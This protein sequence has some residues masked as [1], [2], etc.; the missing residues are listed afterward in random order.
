MTYNLL[1]FND[2]SSRVP[3]FMAILDYAQPD[4]LVVQE[5][6]SQAA[7]DYFRDSILNVVNPGEWSSAAFTDGSEDDNALFYRTAKVEE[8]SHFDIETTSHQIDEWGLRPVGYD[9]PNAELRLYAAHLSP[10]QGGS[11]QQQRLSEVTAMR[12][13]METFP[14]GQN[15]VVCGDLNLYKSDEPAFQYMLSSDNGAAGLVADPMNAPGDW[16]DGEEFV[17]LHTQATRTSSGGGGMDDRFDFILRAPALEDDEGLDLLEPTYAA[18]GQDGL[19]FNA[20]IIDPPANA[21]VPQDIAQALYTASDH[22]PVLVDFQLPPIIVASDALDFGVA[23][24]GGIVPRDVSISNGAAAPADELDYTLSAPGPF[25][26]P[27]GSFQVE[28]GAPANVHTIIMSSDIAGTFA[29]N[30]TIASDDLDSPE[31]FI[32]LAG[33][34]WNHAQPSTVVDSVLTVAAV[35]FGTHAPGE[36]QDQTAVAYNFGFGPLQAKLNV[37]SASL[38]GDPRFSLVGEFAPVSV[39]STPAIWSFHF[40]DAGAPDGTYEALLVLGTEDEGGIPGGTALGDLSYSLMAT[41]GGSAVDAPTG[42]AIG[43]R[44]GL[45][46][47]SP[48]PSPGSTRISF[49]ASRTGRIELRIHD[50]AGRVVRN[51]IEAERDRGE[52]D[53]LW[54]GRDGRGLSSAAGIYFVRLNSMDGSWT[55]KITRV[56]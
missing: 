50:L 31:R 30:L 25:A 8:L 47:I 26:A 51:L 18:L 7:V 28:V 24:V 5:V 53:I 42:P 15:Y 40:D 49:G 4:V 3:H 23:I 20:A 27:E 16:H 45:I 6:G 32:A 33:E 37:T 2:G 1:T 55:Q 11:A 34:V 10:N 29:E 46:A 12:T 36:F 9:S 54:D 19:H 41:I 39:D 17:L 13:R 35:D 44:I 21:L 43:P 38:Q 22:L 14:A 52:H 48:N 56:K